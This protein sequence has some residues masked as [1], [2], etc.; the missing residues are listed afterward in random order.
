MHARTYFLSG[1][2]KI[3]FCKIE[4]ME[5]PKVHSMHFSKEFFR[6]HNIPLLVFGV[7]PH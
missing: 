5:K 4:D 3:R 7:E 6:V 2:V 1:G